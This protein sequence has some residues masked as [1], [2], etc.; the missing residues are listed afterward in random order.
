MSNEQQI[1]Q[2]VTILKGRKVLILTTSNRWSG[3]ADKP[4]STQL[5]EQLASQI[6]AKVIDAA[7]LKIYPCEGNVSTNKG[8]SCGLLDSALKD[9]DKNPTGHHRCWASL[10]N[11]DD[12][13]WKISKELFEAEVVLFFASVRWGQ[14]N[15]I[16]QKLI[17]RLNWLENRWTTLKEDNLLKG[18]DAGIVLVGHN[19][20]G[21]AVLK[22]QKEVLRF[23]GFN[24]PEQL[25]F[26]WQ[27]TTDMFDESAEGYKQ[28]PKDFNSDFG[29]GPKWLSESFEKWFNK[30]DNGED[31]FKTTHYP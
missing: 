19:W 10:N 5:A 8:N 7:S 4:K 9:A 31:G 22:T 28:E 29:L 20:N 17:E 12:E 2:W 27:W 30:K 16:Y 25:S 15:A 24:V 13:L 18:K 23:Y 1:Q 6:G 21:E 11:A 3:S 26:N 14:T